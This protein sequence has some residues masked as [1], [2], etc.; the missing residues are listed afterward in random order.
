MRG[1]QFGFRGTGSRRGGRVRGL[2]LPS[3]W[4]PPS[5]LTKPHSQEWLC[6]LR[7][8]CGITAL[9]LD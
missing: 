8:P 2:L 6:Y 3:D 7:L 9:T 4:Q 5:R 1:G